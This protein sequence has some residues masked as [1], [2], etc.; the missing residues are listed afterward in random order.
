MR[1]R[2]GP[3]ARLSRLLINLPTD[4]GLLRP[5]RNRPRG[6]GATEQRSRRRMWSM[7]CLPWV[8]HCGL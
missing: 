6:R 5:R 8:P 2:D 7:E 3:T 1:Q 4:R